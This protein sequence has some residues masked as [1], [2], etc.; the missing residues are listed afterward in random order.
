MNMLTSIVTVI[1]IRMNSMLISETKS[2]IFH[3]PSTS[4]MKC[5]HGCLEFDV[6]WYLKSLW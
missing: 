1:E 3:N 5:C 6:I 2:D 4:N